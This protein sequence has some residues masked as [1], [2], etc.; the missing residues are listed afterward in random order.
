MIKHN[1]FPDFDIYEL[2]KKDEEHVDEI[3][4]DEEMKEMANVPKYKVEKRDERK[5]KK[6]KTWE[7]AEGS[8]RKNCIK[9]WALNEQSW[10]IFWII[11][12]FCY[13]KQGTLVQLNSVT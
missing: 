4:T 7:N 12:I 1:Q 13:T 8:E 11:K 5:K 2:P 6:R 9:L 10:Y 3:Q